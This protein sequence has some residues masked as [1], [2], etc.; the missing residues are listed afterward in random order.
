[1]IEILEEISINAPGGQGEMG[2][3]EAQVIMGDDPKDAPVTV[4]SSSQQDTLPR[5]AEMWSVLGHPPRCP[6]ERG[7][8][9]ILTIW[10]NR[11]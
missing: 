5:R 4:S 10:A 8:S 9:G 2:R 7:C 1:M 3:T 6:F 11:T